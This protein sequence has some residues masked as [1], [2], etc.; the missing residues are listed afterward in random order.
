MVAGSYLEGSLKSEGA[1]G[2]AVPD[3]VQHRTP[4]SRRNGREGAANQSAARCGA[5]KLRETRQAHE[6]RRVAGNGGAQPATLRSLEV[7][8]IQS[9][10]SVKAQNRL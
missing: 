4:R 1:A 3:G 8:L 6:G 2:A 5:R 9:L 10:M 7:D